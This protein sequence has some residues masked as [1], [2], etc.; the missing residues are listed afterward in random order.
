MKSRETKLPIK[1]NSGRMTRL[2]MVFERQ[3]INQTILFSKEE[4]LVEI[5]LESRGYSSP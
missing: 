1:L 3:D 5:Q 2:N 4:S